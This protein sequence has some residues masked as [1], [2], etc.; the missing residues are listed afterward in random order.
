MVKE[1]FSQRSYIVSPEGEIQ[2][3][4][5]PVEPADSTKTNQERMLP[6]RIE[7]KETGVV[8]YNK[9]ETEMVRSEKKETGMTRYTKKETGIATISQEETK[10]PVRVARQD[11]ATQIE[12]AKKDYVNDYARNVEKM[13]GFKRGAA[14]VLNWFGFKNKHTWT[15]PE[16]KQS[17][18]HYAN[19]NELSL[20]KRVI[21]V[22]KDFVNGDRVRNKR[23]DAKGNETVTAQ[24]AFKRYR[25][26][27][28]TIEQ[29]REEERRADGGKAYL[30]EM[31]KTRDEIQAERENAWPKS[32]VMENLKEKIA[33]LNQNKIFRS[34]VGNKYVR[35]G[36]TTGVIGF[37]TGGLGNVLFYGTR[38]ARFLGGAAAGGL[39]RKGLDAWV[40]EEKI[41][42]K[43]IDALDAQYQSKAITQ[44]Q[45]DSKRLR[46]DMYMN[47]IKRGKEAAGI[48]AGLV[49]A[50]GAGY[51]AHGIGTMID[52]KIGTP[53]MP[54]DIASEHPPVHTNPTPVQDPESILPPQYEYPSAMPVSSLGA[55]DTIEKYKA[56]LAAF[57][58]DKPIPPVAQHF[59]DTPTADLAKEIG[60]WD[61]NAVNESHIMPKGSTIG[62]KDGA[63]SY[64]NSVTG[65]DT[66]VLKTLG[67]RAGDVVVPTSNHLDM[68]DSDVHKNIPAAQTDASLTYSSGMSGGHG[69][70]LER[71]EGMLP[72]G[73]DKSDAFINMPLEIEP[74]P[75]GELEMPVLEREALARKALYEE[76][77]RDQQP[78]IEGTSSSTN[79]L[80]AEEAARKALY[81]EM[82]H[83]DSHDGMANAKPIPLKEIE[84]QPIPLVDESELK[85]QNQPDV[86][87]SGQEVHEKVSSLSQPEQVVRL[88]NGPVT[89]TIAVT[90]DPNGKYTFANSTWDLSPEGFDR[91]RADYAI[92]ENLANDIDIAIEKIYLPNTT[93]DALATTAVDKSQ[94]L[95]N[96][97]NYH[98]YNVLLRY[99]GLD[100][101]SPVY[102]AALNEAQKIQASIVRNY[103]TGVLR[104]ITTSGSVR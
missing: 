24:E 12:T 6:A 94:L 57:Y 49:G 35:F 2:P 28:D 55:L 42:Q 8:Q 56:Q 84:S 7:N 26:I 20:L 10:K 95:T 58:V 37:A 60:A 47:R 34:T 46:I 40:K 13:S 30:T 88:S 19:R 100:S 97:R 72:E 61:P 3:P 22:E 45:Y 51:G 53:L 98:L 23:F 44:S 63:L 48:A 25:R 21:E 90:L 64:H 17:E 52:S 1:Q 65:A 16:L 86:I 82:T 54:H 15:N 41:L 31:K 18:E 5:I 33:V 91:M 83:P 74:E 43:E 59:M 71:E 102:Q 70:V 89:G 92:P 39:A 103:G 73:G 101:Q 50:T 96:I 66:E 11:L 4:Q 69:T 78:V 85:V 81:E 76:V 77:M 93:I 14:K 38:A 9:K 32:K 68:F 99:S 27:M 104:D 87:T 67:S 36:L 62:M 80:T 75:N 79:G 29:R